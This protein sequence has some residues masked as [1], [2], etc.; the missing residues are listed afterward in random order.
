MGTI[1]SFTDTETILDLLPSVL[2]HGICHCCIRLYDMMSQES[3]GLELSLGR[4]Y[5]Y[6]PPQ[7]KIQGYYT[8]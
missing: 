7:E 8:W 5:F 6:V 3:E 1:H 4:Q 2:E